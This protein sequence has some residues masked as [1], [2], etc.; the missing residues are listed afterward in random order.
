MRAFLV[1][2][3]ALAG[4]ASAQAPAQRSFGHFPYAEASKASLRDRVC[5]R[6]DERRFLRAEAADALA[7]MQA[8]A[9]ADG[10]T[11]NPASCFRAISS[12]RALFECRGIASATGCKDGRRTSEA[13]R[14]RAVAPPGHSEH[15]T[16]YAIDFFPSRADIEAGVC[17]TLDAC[18]TRAA[19]AR[20][21]SG[22]WLAVNAGR[23]GFELSFWQ[24]SPQGVTYEPWHWRYVGSAEAQ[25]VFA[26]ARAQF[27]P[28]R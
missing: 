23:F 1:V 8:A 6:G 28:P 27:P 2:F 18:T 24:G 16:G 19:F 5:S 11:L 4:F 20:S 3:L 7:R 21:R 26:G 22:R 10:V 14:A 17:P 12:Q 13:E 25:A 9:R 15:H